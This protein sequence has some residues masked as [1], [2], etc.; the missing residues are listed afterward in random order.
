VTA[1]VIIVTVAVSDDYRIYFQQKAVWHDPRRKGHGRIDSFRSVAS[2]L[3][4][5][6]CYNTKTS[7][8]TFKL[9]TADVV[10]IVT[11]AISDDYR[12]YFQQKSGLA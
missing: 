3:I 9:V 1:D 5:L 2:M 6:F 4:L 12:I 8:C 10:I 7:R 11:V